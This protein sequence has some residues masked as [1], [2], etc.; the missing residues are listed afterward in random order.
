LKASK[1]QSAHHKTTGEQKNVS[2]INFHM[3]ILS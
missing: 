1:E 2:P 3:E